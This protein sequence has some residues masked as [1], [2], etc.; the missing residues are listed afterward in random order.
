MATF[1][2]KLIHWLRSGHREEM[3]YDVETEPIRERAEL[4]TSK[5]FSP[6]AHVTS[7]EKAVV[8]EEKQDTPPLWFSEEEN[9]RDEG[10]LFGLSESE[11]T[12]KTDIIHK[13]FTQIATDH[14]AEIEQKNEKVQEYNLFIGQNT[15][16]ITMLSSRLK[17]HT[18]RSFTHQHFL[19]RT[20][21]GLS[22]SLVICIGNFFLI[23]ESLQVDYPDGFLIALGVFFAGMFNVFGKVSFFHDDQQKANWRTLLEETGMPAAA[24]L[25]VLV[26]VIAYQPLWAAFGL[27][28]FI[29]FLFLFAGKLML[30]NVTMLRNDLKIWQEVRSESRKVKSEIEYWSDE[31]ADLE[32]RTSELR[33]EKWQVLRELGTAEAARDRLFAK[34]DM[35]IKTFES[36][37]Y[38][39]RRMKSQLS[40]KQLNYIQDSQE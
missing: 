33:I 18:E 17:D 31:I 34:R 28:V 8:Q 37:F 22:L 7:D 11:P 2:E 25:F 40:K 36:E 10:V 39:A 4:E 21:L 23:Q 15:D 26:H 32:K 20:M 6:E 1:R 5:S 38:L 12:E 30:S 16:R 35:L 27:F 29:L 19:P 24:A 9:L 3:T 14:I 13:Y